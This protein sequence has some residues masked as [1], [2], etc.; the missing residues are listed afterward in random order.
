[1]LSSHAVITEHL[2]NVLQGIALKQLTGRLSIEHV[3]V[4]GSEK[5]EIFFVQGNTSFARTMCETGETALYN[6]LQWKDSHYSFFEGDQVSS[7]STRPRQPRLAPLSQSTQSRT[8]LPIELEA[9][10]QTPAIGMPVIP[11][12]LR[13]TSIQSPSSTLPPA[14]PPTPTHAI[15]PQHRESS[16]Q[17]GMF[18]IFRA[19][20]SA[21]KSSIINQMDRKDR[22]VFL[23]LD[24]RRT[25]HTIKHLVNRSD[26]EVVQ[27][28]VRL[29]KQGYVEYIHG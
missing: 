13:H 17:P 16:A 24:G 6:M 27:I 12:S 19:I 1:M 26:A 3:G 28:L 2:V 25:L 20:P 22:I 5:G 18:A 23:L 14:Q 9:T 8:L 4:Q 21:K 15:M 29:L 11:K 10:R 7:G